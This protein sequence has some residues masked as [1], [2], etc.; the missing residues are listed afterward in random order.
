MKN[1]A[2]DNEE[3]DNKQTI[4]NINKLILVNKANIII[5]LRD[6]NIKKQ[7]VFI[8]L[9]RKVLKKIITNTLKKIQTISKWEKKINHILI[10]L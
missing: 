8:F 9:K 3:I 6:E 7:K 1:K 2:D 5:K 4:L 10:L